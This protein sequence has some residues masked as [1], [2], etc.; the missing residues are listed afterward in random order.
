MIL[1]RAKQ[2]GVG[3]EVDM[4]Q[5]DLVDGTLD[6]SGR[7]PPP[8]RRPAWR[9]RRACAARCP[10][11]SRWRVAN[12][13]CGWSRGPTPSR[14]TLAL[15]SKKEITAQYQYLTD[16]LFVHGSLPA[17]GT[18]DGTCIEYAQKAA[19]RAGVGKRDF[20]IQMLYGIRRDLQ[21]ALAADGYRVAVYIPF[22]SAWYP[23]LMRRMAE[24]PANLRFFLRSLVGG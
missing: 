6:C 20:E 13:G 22:G 11:W 8:T 23:Y 12:P 7:P 5:S 3:V 4:E 14:S 19:A 18:H 16:W 9:S 2:L 15:R 21:Q 24:R 1:E 17:F 10:T